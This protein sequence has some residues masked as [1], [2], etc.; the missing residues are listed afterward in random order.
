M[1]KLAIDGGIPVRSE[2]DSSPTHNF[3][4][5]DVA[6]VESVIKSGVLLK[7]PAGPEVSAFQDEYAKRYGIKYGVMVNSGTSAMHTCVGALNPDPGDEIITTAWTSGGSI[8]GILLQNCVPIFADIDET[9][10]LDPAEV[11]SKITSR[12][13]AILVVNLMGNIANV[14]EL[15][16]IAD[17]HGI[18]LIEDC[19]QSHFS[20][21]NG[22]IAGSLADIAGVSFGGKH[23]N[24]GAGGMVLT[25]NPDLWDRARLFIDAA[26]PRRTTS[27]DGEPYAN[28]FLAPN[29]KVYEIMGAMGRV[30]LKKVDSYVDAKIRSATNIIEGLSDF[31]EITAQKVRPGVKHTYWGLRFTLDTEALNCT[32]D[33]YAAAVSAEGIPCSGP[34]IGTPEHGPLYRNPFLSEPNLYGNSRFPLDYNRETPIDYRK[35]KNSFGD[36]F[37][38]KGIGF[39]MKPFFTEE[40]VGQIIEANK[41]VITSFKQRSK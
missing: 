6:A 14:R 30:Q 24:L 4:E 31:E 35:V 40:Y 7:V 15:R 33:E 9:M 5:D 1:S 3:G 39:S 25:N 13:K 2:Q 26:L 29:Y 32:P 20:E 34:Y 16:K 10:C 11:E 18:Y 23:L 27:L 8:I 37:M 12:T 19:C 38:S 22:V 36:N 41:K 28:Y 17:K 21:D